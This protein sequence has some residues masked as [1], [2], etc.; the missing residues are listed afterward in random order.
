MN[1]LLK[2]IINSFLDILFLFIRSEKKRVKVYSLIS[3]ILFDKNN[4]LEYDN[5]FYG[6]W[7]KHSNQYLFFVKKPYFNFSKKNLFKSINDI[8]CKNYTPKSEDV[9]IDIGAGIGTEVLYFN[10]KIG[11][12]GKIYSIEASTDSYNKLDALCVKN[13]ITNSIN[14]N[15]AISN[16]NGKIWIEETENFEVN[17]VNKTQKGIEV[18]CYTLDEFVKNNHITKINFLKVNI[19]GAEFDLV[20]GMAESINIIDNIAISC[21]DF[22]FGDGEKIKQKIISFLTLNNFE[23]AINNTG[24]KVTDSWVY[25]KKNE[26][27]SGNK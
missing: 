9:I 24:N 15:L 27:S 3:K 10:D 25:G 5:N 6:Y 22:L 1:K 19:E 7:L 14:F 17:R 20:D 12:S 4:N 16:F 11:K 26:N 18:N 13:N 8:Y 21:H 23:I 2:I